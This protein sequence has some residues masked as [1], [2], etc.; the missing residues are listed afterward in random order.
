[1][2]RTPDLT[3]HVHLW[4]DDSPTVEIYLTFR[5]QLRASPEDRDRYAAT[6][7]DLATRNWPTMNHYAAAKTDVIQL[8]LNHSAR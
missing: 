3:V 6:K 2:L 5:D 7:R 4:T 1:M 8:I